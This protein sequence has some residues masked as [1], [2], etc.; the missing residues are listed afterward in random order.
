MIE[1]KD[2]KGK[3]ILLNGRK[4]FPLDDPKNPK[5]KLSP[6]QSYLWKDYLADAGETYTYKA[7]AMFGT[8]D[9]YGAIFFPHL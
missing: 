4:F 5:Q 6:I 3:K 8:W 2:S 1:R 9:N 7:D